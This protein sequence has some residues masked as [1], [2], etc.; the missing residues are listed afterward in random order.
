MLLMTNYTYRFVLCIVFGKIM[1]GTNRDI[2]QVS[3]VGCFY[4]IFLRLT[5]TLCYSLI[6]NEFIQHY[7]CV[8]DG[9]N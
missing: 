9:Y 2:I 5:Q 8:L 7:I 6:D 4:S 1:G 3:R